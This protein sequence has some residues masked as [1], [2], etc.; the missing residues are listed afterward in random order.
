[1]SLIEQVILQCSTVERE[2]EVMYLEEM[3][4][5]NIKRVV[6]EYSKEVL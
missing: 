5:K 3:K 4:E 2:L 1:M 6:R